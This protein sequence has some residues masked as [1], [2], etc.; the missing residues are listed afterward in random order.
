MAQLS[1]GIL[2]EALLRE[3]VSHRRRKERTLPCE[4]KQRYKLGTLR[5]AS[6]GTL[7]SSRRKQLLPMSWFWT[8]SNLKTM[9]Q[10][11]LVISANPLCPICDS[12]SGKLRHIHSEMTTSFQFKQIHVTSRQ[13]NKQKSPNSLRIPPTHTHF[14][15]L[16]LIPKVILTSNSMDYFTH[17]K[18]LWMEPYGMYCLI[19][20]S[21]TQDYCVCENH[22]YCSCRLCFPL[23]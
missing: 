14:Q 7:Q 19:L 1:E 6:I 18:F 13:I 3:P 16:P 2:L 23:L 22:P 11:I 10:L 21:F 17:M 20:A 5:I 9:S 4:E 12:N 15:S 8:S